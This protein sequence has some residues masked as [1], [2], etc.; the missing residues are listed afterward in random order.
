ME[1]KQFFFLQK[2]R[3]ECMI[4]RSKSTSKTTSDLNFI[5]RIIQAFIVFVPRLKALT[6]FPQ[7]YNTRQTLTPFPSPRS[8][9]RALLNIS[10]TDKNAGKFYEKALNVICAHPIYQCCESF[11]TFFYPES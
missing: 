2:A 9:F 6:L 1:I 7:A 8:T 4:M 10:N 11:V 3:E 5:V